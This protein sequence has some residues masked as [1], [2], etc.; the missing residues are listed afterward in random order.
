MTFDD[1]DDVDA[2]RIWIARFAGKELARG[3]LPECLTAC[4]KAEAESEAAADML[5]KTRD[6]QP[7]TPAELGLPIELPDV[8]FRVGSTLATNL[9]CLVGETL[10]DG[11]LI[12]V[13]LSTGRDCP[14]FI[15]RIGPVTDA[16]EVTLAACPGDPSNNPF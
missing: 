5:A 15:R 11:Q 13:G 2:P 10:T 4:E 7:L 9:R 16:Y 1:S 6:G 14:H 12:E 3:S 8:V